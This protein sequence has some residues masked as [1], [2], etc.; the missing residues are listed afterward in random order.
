M[1]TDV[2]VAL[3]A[4]SAGADIVRRRF[5]G[6]LRR[7]DKGHGDFA[8][9][10]DIAAEEAIVEIIRTER[11]DDS[12][13]AEESGATGRSGNHRT[14]LVDPICGT[15][16]YY[17]GTGP[18]AVNVALNQNDRPI[19]GA[20]AD[21][22]VNEIYWTDGRTSVRRHDQVDQA[23]QP[24]SRSK[25]IDI[26]MDPPFPNRDWFRPHVLA[27]DETFTQ[28][29]EPRVVSSTIALTW[30][31]TG[32]RAA[33]VTDGGLLG[34]VHFA[35]A[36]AICEAAGVVMTNLAGGSIHTGVE[37]LLAAADQ[38]THQQLTEIVNAVP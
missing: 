33:Y 37:G 1:L 19:A 21:P 38:E 11:P 35:A 26:N 34:S 30:V 10:V 8:T 32:Q 4:V 14:W 28:W 31:A 7:L 20:V 3:T 13:H 18:V 12:I 17:A 36:L 24:S 27:S 16:N 15:T 29:F 25:L 6:E 23:L 2:E 9:D 22:L 5:G